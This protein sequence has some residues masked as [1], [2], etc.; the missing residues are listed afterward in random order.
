MPEKLGGFQ[1][2]RDILIPGIHPAVQDALLF[3]VAE[4]ADSLH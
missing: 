3:P 1:C 4:D 2:I